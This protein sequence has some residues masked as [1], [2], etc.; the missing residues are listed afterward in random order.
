[1]RRSTTWCYR[2]IR[3]N[4]RVLHPAALLAAA[5]RQFGACGGVGLHFVGVVPEV[6]DL[7]TDLVGSG[8]LRVVSDS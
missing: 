7:L 5:G 8:F 4:N 3:K 6:A 1:M 2:C